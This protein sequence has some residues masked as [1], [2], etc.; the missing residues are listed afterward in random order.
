MGKVRSDFCKYL[1]EFYQIS[2]NFFSHLTDFSPQ[3]MACLANPFIFKVGL[4]IESWFWSFHEGYEWNNRRI[5][6]CT[7]EA[8]PTIQ[9]T[10]R[11]FHAYPL[12]N[13]QNQLSILKSVKIYA[14]AENNFTKNCMHT[15]WLS[16]LISYENCVFV[17]VSSAKMSIHLD[18]TITYLSFLSCKLIRIFLLGIGEIM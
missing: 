4:R 18:S 13:N 14:F 5:H 10:H 11:L 3:L 2:Q 8:M 17:S 16:I 12:W 6:F 15:L 9:C 7:A 1:I